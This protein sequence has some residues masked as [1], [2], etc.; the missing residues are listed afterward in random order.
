VVNQAGRLRL[1]DRQA[2]TMATAGFFP[3]PR[4]LTTEVVGSLLSHLSGTKAD[5]LGAVRDP[6]VPEPNE[7]IQCQLE[8]LTPFRL[9]LRTEPPKEGSAAELQVF[10]DLIPER[11]DFAHRMAAAP[12]RIA[13]VLE[14]VVA[15]IPRHQRVATLVEEAP[16]LLPSG[17]A[18][19]EAIRHSTL[20][21]VRIAAMKGFVRVSAA[22]CPTS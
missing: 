5:L 10:H 19:P 6:G 13:P 17:F 16:A 9:G 14:P 12:H 3:M 20:E 15:A 1:D 2:F 22:P 8:T 18:S 21:L 11:Q 7:L 4:A